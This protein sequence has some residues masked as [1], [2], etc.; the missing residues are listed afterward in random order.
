MVIKTKTQTGS[1]TT[2]SHFGPRLNLMS[3]F[4]VQFLPAVPRMSFTGHLR[5]PLVCCVT[6]QGKLTLN[7][8]MTLETKGQLCFILFLF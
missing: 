2:S 5:H 8:V 1:L 6:C 7:Q 3:G 4:Q